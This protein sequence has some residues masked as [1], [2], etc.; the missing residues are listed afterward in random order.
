MEDKDLEQQP[1]TLEE[2][3]IE[4][5]SKKYLDEIENMKHNTVS[6]Q[7]YIRLQKENK[8]LYES[9]KNG[10]DVSTDTSDTK[11]DVNDLRKDL[12]TQDNTNL[13]FWKKALT[14]RKTLMDEG[15]QDPFLPVGH[16]IVPT[17]EDIA[18]ANRV[19]EGVAECIKYADGDP[20]VFTN[21]LQRITIDTVPIRRK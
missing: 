5:I 19:A 13:D 21:E 20:N 7:E 3:E 18:A 15:N 8:T 10:R 16:N 14:L 12:F 4:D 17:D 6:K 9:I 1:R 2:D 11:V